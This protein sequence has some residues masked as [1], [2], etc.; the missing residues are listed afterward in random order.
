MSHESIHGD[1]QQDSM[2]GT[3][4]DYNKIAEQTTA[5]LTAQGQPL[6]VASNGLTVANSTA[7]PPSSNQKQP[8]PKPP[9]SNRP[10]DYSRGRCMMFFPT[11]GHMGFET[12]KTSS[13][14]PTIE[15]IR[16][17]I[18]YE[19][20]IRL[21]ESIQQLMDVYYKDEGAITLIL[22][23]I[24]QHVVESFGYRDVNAL[25]TALY[26]FPDEPA[27]KD[28]FYIKHNK[29]TQG[30]ITQD[31]CIRDV[32]LFSLEGRPTNLLSHIPAGQPLIL[33]AGSTS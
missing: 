22:D 30:L 18:A 27:V 20:G 3:E 13:E 25:R 26:R 12:I 4:Q 5:V 9:K 2:N 10:T 6:S 7:L 28:A 33:L 8:P 16:E 17:M 11:S 21:S 19:T 15:T 24:Q 1:R 14:S 29:I 23:L 32:D 31:Q